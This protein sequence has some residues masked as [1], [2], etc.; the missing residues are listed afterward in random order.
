MNLLKTGKK[1]T[2]EGVTLIELLL[3]SSMMVLLG[4]AVYGTF[5]LG[6]AVHRRAVTDK[7]KNETV[8]FSERLAN[9][10]R[11]IRPFPES[12][13]NGTSVGMVFHVHDPSYLVSATEAEMKESRPIS[14]VEYVYDISSKSIVRRAYGYGGTKPYYSVT[15]LSGAENVAFGYLK[16]EEKALKSVIF[17]KNTETTPGAVKIEVFGKDPN[18]ALFS[19]ILD[20]PISGN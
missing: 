10:L 12:E 3:V 20:V 18:R 4:M 13:F 16:A 9:D 6:L 15:V 14:R 7:P 5:S 2:T 8:V 19:R 17:E 1:G 11:N